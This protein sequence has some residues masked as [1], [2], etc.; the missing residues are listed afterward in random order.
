V[1]R[2]EALNSPFL[3]GVGDAI[4]FLLVD[5]ARLV[6]VQFRLQK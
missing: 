1:G 3:R 6:D 5:I 2:D 4:R